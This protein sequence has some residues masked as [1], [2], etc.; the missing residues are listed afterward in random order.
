LETRKREGADVWVTVDSGN[1]YLTDRQA[2]FSGSKVVKFRYDK[3]VSEQVTA[4]GLCLA[5]SNRMRSHI[6]SGP[7]EKTAALITASQAV[8]RGDTA[9]SPFTA[10][11]ESLKRIVEGIEQQLD[12]ERSDRS[13]LVAPPRPIS[14]GWIP[15]SFVLVVLFMGSTL[16]GP[17]DQ[18]PVAAESTTTTAEPVDTPTTRHTT[19]SLATTTT[20][21]PTTTSSTLPP[22]PQA[23]VIFAGPIAG[24]SGDPNARLPPNTEIVTVA[25]IT[26]GDTL[27]VTFAD[28][29]TEPL[30]LIGINSPETPECWA[31]EAELALTALTPVGSRIGLS[32]DVSDRDQFDR[33]LRYLWV[34][35][36]SVNEE[37]VRRGAAISRRYP[38]DTSLATRLETAQDAARQSGIG[39]WAP[40]ACGPPA[41]A[42]LS[43]GDLF[44]DAPGNDND[45]LNEEWIEIRNDGDNLADM[46]GWGIRD[47]SASNR[48][49]FPAAYSLA[50]GET[51]TIHS[52]CGDD[53]G[54]L[55]FWCS[56]GSAIWNNDGDTA[57]LT[58]PNG[59]THTS[60]TYS[61]PTTTT[62]SPPTTSAGGEGGGDCHPSYQGECVPDG[63]SDVDC[64]GGSGDGPYYVG[65]VT[66]VGPDVYGL[67]H[68]NDGVGC[69]NS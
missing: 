52:G 48:Y 58:D 66:V 5:V 45:N 69:E 2:I 47:E 57:F 4:D 60:S 9:A 36:M 7:A 64:L 62:T 3:L 30:R 34:G 31:S 22:V 19:T 46:T 14:P 65:R 11:S 17:A 29:T 39:L 25:S 38:P 44:Y 15:A 59:N 33:L 43:I 16:A 23:E 27:K 54:T 61:P 8:A 63:V 67:D 68:N 37:L 35:G 32:F 6:L 13:A 24:A 55:L 28:G 18:D 41:A 53:F 21:R 10:R 42:T 12:E 20:S 26:D 51:V 1:L 50:A 49:T 56:V 40:D